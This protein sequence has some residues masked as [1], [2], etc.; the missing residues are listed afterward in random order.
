MTMI[1]MRAT[2]STTTKSIFT[3]D[4]GDNDYDNDDDGSND[5]DNN[6]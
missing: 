5:D 3:L 6:R 1:I 4:N 2:I